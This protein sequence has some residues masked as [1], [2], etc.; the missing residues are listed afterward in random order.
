MKVTIKPSSGG[1][2]ESLGLTRNLD[3]G[4]RFGSALLSDPTGLL[5]NGTQQP[6]EAR[7]ASG[8][9]PDRHDPVLQGP[10]PLAQ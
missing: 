3:R 6:D 5:T 1:R 9:Q 2:A 4:R 10:Q 7:P 8:R